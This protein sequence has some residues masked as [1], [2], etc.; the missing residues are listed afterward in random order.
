[1]AKKYRVTLTA[2]ER[3]ELEGLI[4]RGK[5]AA[6]KLTHARVLLQVDESERGPGKADQDAASALNV[7]V[8]TI[9]RLRQR[10]VEQGFEAALVPARSKRIYARKLDGKQEAKLIALACAKPPAGK[11]RWT[12]RL[13]ADE[14]VELEIANSLSHETVRQTLKKTSSSRI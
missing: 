11:K 12:L 7:N 5:G 2:K 8:R 1:M 14:A 3:H 9:E 4:S 6:R 13:L 10:F